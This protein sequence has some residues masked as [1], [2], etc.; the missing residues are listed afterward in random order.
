MSSK[1]TYILYEAAT[2]YAVFEQNDAEEIGIK[3][4]QL[5]KSYTDFGVFKNVLKLFSFAPFRTA[6]E[7]LENCN[8]VTEGS[9]SD[10]LKSFLAMTFE[11]PLKKLRKKK[12]EDA[13]CPATFQLGVCSPTLGG[14]IHELLAIPVV[15]NEHI[16]EMMRFIRLHGAKFLPNHGDHELERAQLGLCH[17]YSR[18]KVQFNIN[19]VDNM[20][21]QSSALL[22]HMDKGINQLAMRVKEWYGWHFPELVKL[23]PD[24]V[25][26]AKVALVIGDRNSLEEKTSAK[27]DIENILVESKID[28][29]LVNA[30]LETAGTSMGTDVSDADMQ[31][32]TAYGQKVI[33]LVEYKARLFEYLCGKLKAVAPNLTALLDERLAAK[34]IS[35]T[36]SLTNLA[37]SP[38]STIQILGAEKALFRA[39]KKKGNTPKYG[40][41]FNSTFISRASKENKGRISRYL[42]NKSA[43]AARIDCFMETQPTSIFG[44]TLRAQ[45]EERLQFLQ[46]DDK[47]RVK[48]TSNKEAIQK[49][50]QQY[51]EAM[52]RRMKKKKRSAENESA[53]A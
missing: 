41:I 6:E 42:A 38:A 7:A 47:S 46:S 37:K 43:L 15:S 11:K 5:Q 26:F 31:Q 18:G 12:A 29:E 39:L 40:H 9:V 23:V 53:T 14:T 32:I 8:C 52:E 20:I 24:V 17:S 33:D 10:Y 3:D 44:T 51:K 27:E 35:H 22:E 34:L 13:T 1:K 49:A 36:G 2:G 28:P 48:V 45:L 4:I 19:R 21:L 16:L 50:I 25:P 30:I